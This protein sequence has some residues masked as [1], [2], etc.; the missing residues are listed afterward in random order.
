MT[1]FINNEINEKVTRSEINMLMNLV[2]L[3]HTLTISRNFLSSFLNEKLW[4]TF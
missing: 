2:L 3:F 1:N 4:T